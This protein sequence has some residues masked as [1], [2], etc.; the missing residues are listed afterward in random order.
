MATVLECCSLLA[1][2][3]AM[4]ENANGL[5]AVPRP[6]SAAK[7]VRPNAATASVRTAS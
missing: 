4:Q 6:P 1:A 2:A 3:V 7:A 5:G